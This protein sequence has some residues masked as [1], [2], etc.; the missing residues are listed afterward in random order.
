MLLKGTCIRL[1]L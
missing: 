1:W